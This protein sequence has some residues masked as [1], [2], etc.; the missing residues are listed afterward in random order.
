MD[1]LAV[2][3]VIIHLILIV[4]GL[5]IPAQAQ[6][7]ERVALEVHYLYQDERSHIVCTRRPSQM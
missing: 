6:E 2:A 3:V 7:P 5:S 1:R 4:W